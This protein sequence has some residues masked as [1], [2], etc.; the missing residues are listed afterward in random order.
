M[1]SDYDEEVYRS[2]QVIEMLTVANEFCIFIK[3]AGSWTK[4][5]IL[6]FIIKISPLL[7][8]KGILLPV[9]LVSDPD[10]LERYVTEEQWEQ[11]FMLFREKFGSDDA[12]YLSPLQLVIDGKN[13]KASLAENLA[14]IYQDMKDFVLLY[15]KNTRAAQE[16][17]ASEIRH[18]F[19]T[20]W[21]IRI[22]HLLR[23]LHELRFG[24]E[25]VTEG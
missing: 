8:L 14:D 19:E 6:D 4:E 22:I 2:R 23:H 10:A 18:L 9:V 13:H 24:K 5:D 11:V 1:K 16:N 21:G 20:H 17:A 25:Q 7:Y 3:G 12:F 15:Q